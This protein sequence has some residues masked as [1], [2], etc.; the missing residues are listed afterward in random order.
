MEYSNMSSDRLIATRVMTGEIQRIR[1]MI[2]QGSHD[3]EFLQQVINYLEMRIESMKQK[4]GFKNL[5]KLYNLNSRSTVH[6]SVLKRELNTNT[7][8]Q[9]CNTF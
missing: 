6:F 3:A 9:L 1:L 2:E 5:S 8:G 4:A 7:L